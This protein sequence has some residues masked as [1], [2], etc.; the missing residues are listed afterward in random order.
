MTSDLLRGTPEGKAVQATKLSYY[1]EPDS[2]YIRLSGRPSAE[3][4][5]I[6]EGGMALASH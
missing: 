3:S 1:R 2:L 5:E 6:S 4:H